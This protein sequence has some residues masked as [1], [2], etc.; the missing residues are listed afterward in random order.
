MTEGLCKDCERWRQLVRNKRKGTFYP[1]GECSLPEEPKN[2]WMWL[3]HYGEGATLM[4]NEN[5]GCNQWKQRDTSP[6]A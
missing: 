5:F 4:T 2:P 3:E 6:A 1:D